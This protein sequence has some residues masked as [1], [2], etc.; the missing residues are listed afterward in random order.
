M[1]TGN[2]T[3]TTATSMVSREMETTITVTGT[4]SGVTLSIKLSDETGTF[5]TIP[6]ETYTADFSKVLRMGR[7]AQFQLVSSGATDL[8]YIANEAKQL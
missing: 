1:A 5:T 3:N 8:D 7:N 6:G 2:I 4:W